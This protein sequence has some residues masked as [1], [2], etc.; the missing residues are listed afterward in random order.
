MSRARPQLAAND[1]TTVLVDYTPDPNGTAMFLGLAG[2]Q[3]GPMQGLDG[4]VYAGDRGSPERSFNG[5]MGHDLQRFTGAAPLALYGAA[6]PIS[7]TSG[8]F[9][10]ARSADALDDAPL[11]IF[12]ARAN[13]RHRGV[14]G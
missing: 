1:R 12:A 10:T 5:D 6:K 8:T 11:R 9:E 13:R 14:P 7:P 3:A 4:Q 2:Q